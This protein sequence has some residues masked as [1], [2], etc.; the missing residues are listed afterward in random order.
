MASVRSIPTYALSARQRKEIGE[1]GIAWQILLPEMYEPPPTLIDLLAFARASLPDVDPSWIVS[2]E[3]DRVPIAADRGKPDGTIT[4]QLGR[5]LDDR[6]AA[7][8]WHIVVSV[9]IVTIRRPGG[10][11]LSKRLPQWPLA[12]SRP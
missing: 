12:V 11:A 8:C 2:A 6:E 5:L 3:A 9:V 1:R 7:N 10:R 4:G